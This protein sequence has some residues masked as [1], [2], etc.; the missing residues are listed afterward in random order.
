[1]REN[2]IKIIKLLIILKEKNLVYLNHKNETKTERRLK[3]ARETP[4][5]D[6]ELKI[7]V[8]LYSISAGP[9]KFAD[10]KAKTEKILE[11]KVHSLSLINIVSNFESHGYIRTIE[12]QHP[13]YKGEKYYFPTIRG[14]KQLLL[15]WGFVASIITKELYEEIFAPSANINFNQQIPI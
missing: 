4:H 10:F 3:M 5:L 11:R 8:V 13:L 9:H 2:L 1:M 12:R 6:N 7:W 15:G 14:R